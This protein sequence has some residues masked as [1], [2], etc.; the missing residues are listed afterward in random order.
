M[1]LK[2][3]LSRPSLYTATAATLFGLVLGSSATLASHTGTPAAAAPVAQHSNSVT[4]AVRPA[5]AASAPDFSQTLPPG[6]PSAAIADTE[7]S[8]RLYGNDPYQ[9]AVAVTRHVYTASQPL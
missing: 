4:S 7:Y 2:T 6:Q 3:R 8:T 1:S 9:E 5:A